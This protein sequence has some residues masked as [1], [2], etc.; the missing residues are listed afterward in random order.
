MDPYFAAEQ[1]VA[2][3]ARSGVNATAERAGAP[4][5]GSGHDA[6]LAVETFVACAREPVASD[7]RDEQQLG[8]LED[9]D[10]LIYEAWWENGVYTLTFCR[11]FS[12]VGTDEEHASMNRLYLGVILT[13]DLDGIRDSDVIYGAAGRRTPAVLPDATG[14]YQG[15]CAD[16]VFAVV[17]A[18]PVD[19]FEIDQGPI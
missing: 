14:W 9:A 1:L 6:R 10:L 18:A 11:Q 8:S 4:W 19:R 12:F 15:V 17:L 2:E 16:A 5:T 3:L 13:A 7:P